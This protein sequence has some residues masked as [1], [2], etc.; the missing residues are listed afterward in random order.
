MRVFSKASRDLLE[1]FWYSGGNE[2]RKASKGRGVAACQA[3]SNSST[4]SRTS[5][6]KPD[7]SAR[8]FSAI[9]HPISSIRLRQP[10]V[11]FFTRITQHEPDQLRRT[12]DHGRNFRSRVAF[13]SQANHLL[14]LRLQA[15]QEEIDF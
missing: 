8:A 7:A 15:R 13:Q 4:R 5:A 14:S 1:M 11:Q 2:A 10:L 9:T 6:L 3:A 12:I